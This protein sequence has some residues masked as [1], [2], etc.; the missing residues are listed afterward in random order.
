MSQRVFALAIG[1]GFYYGGAN[2]NSRLPVAVFRGELQALAVYRRRL[3]P[4]ERAATQRWLA[5][6]YYLQCAALAAPRGA[7]WAGACASARNGAAPCALSCAAGLELAGGATSL[8]C[9]NGAWAGLAP[10]CLAP[11]CGGAPPAAPAGA[12]A[13]AGACS[14]VLARED[15]AAAALA[16]AAAEAAPAGQV[17]WPAWETL[18]ALPPALAA[19]RWSPHSGGDGVGLVGQ[20]APADDECSFSEPTA[21][22]LNRPRAAAGADAGADVSVQATLALDAGASGGLLAAVLAP[23]PGAA[24]AWAATS[25][26]RLT[27]TVAAGG[28]GG[29]GGSAAGALEEV[30]NGSLARSTPFALPPALQPPPGAPVAIELRLRQRLGA[31]DAQVL[32]GGASVL[33]ASGVA[34]GW[35]LP[36]RLASAGLH[37]AA[38]RAVFT[39]FA[40]G[41]SSGAPGGNASAPEVLVDPAATV[42]I[43]SGC[44]G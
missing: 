22:V 3:S 36:P 6:R 25:F 39:A 8:S 21:L 1:G 23:A 41:A 16:A 40:T 43:V 29:S 27:L 38:G 44:A 15:F 17:L 24:D 13:G 28:G 10:V 18:P 42:Y 33:T 34:A 2:G 7:A 12:A 31:L 5:D 19:A 11:A 20:V 30:R 14:Q 26:L 4:A 32:V 9:E 35:P 37:V